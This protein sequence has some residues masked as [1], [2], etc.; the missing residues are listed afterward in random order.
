MPDKQILTLLVI[1]DDPSISDYLSLGFG[2]EGFD[3]KSATTA[4]Q[5]LELFE[6]YNPNVLIMDVGLPGMDGFALLKVIR[7]RSQVPVLMLTARDSVEDR[8]S[9][10]TGGADDY[11]VK[12]FHFG[13]L[14]ARLQAILRRSQPDFGQT[15]SYN[16]LH[17]DTELREAKRSERILELSPRALDVLAVF[18]QHPER[19]LSKTMILD[20]VWGGDFLGDDNIVEVY[21]RQIRKAL[22]Q[23][24]LIH[25]VRGAGYLLRLKE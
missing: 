17:L 15:L 9:G 10:L 22:G 23:P 8:I 14:L 2:Y 13:E 21:V 24:E 18:L 1:E 12:P 5:A 19:T 4:S 6:E 3:V 16:D 11:L 25:T 7:E 20:S